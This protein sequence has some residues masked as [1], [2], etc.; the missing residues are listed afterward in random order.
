LQDKLRRQQDQL[1]E[2]ITARDAKIRDLGALLARRIAEAD[3]SEAAG[4]AAAGQATLTRLVGDLERRLTAERN[5]HSALEKRLERIVAEVRQE[6]EQR[7]AA[8]RREAALRVELEAVEASLQSMSSGAGETAT[9]PVDLDGL[10]LLYVG[11]RPNQ[12]SHLR[13][14]AERQGAGFLQHDGGIEDRTGLL[15]GLVS[16][17]DVVMFPVDCV[18][19]EAMAMVKRLCRQASKPY[20]PL[21]SAGL[22][23]FVAALGR[24]EIAT[25]RGRVASAVSA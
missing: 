7:A 2:G 5:H 20:V 13:A 9:A 11:G 3:D 12:T 25:L 22:S 6:R 16:R 15:A 4:D 8:E 23:A 21:R 19:H 10:L 18:S 24:A 1:R 14:L 17:A